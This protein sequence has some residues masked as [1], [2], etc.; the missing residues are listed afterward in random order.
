MRGV[1]ACGPA[2]AV[3]EGVM[4]VEQQR[5]AGLEQL[6]AG[7]DGGWSVWNVLQETEI[8]SKVLAT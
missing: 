5:R 7:A 6:N 1:R 3:V 4:E 2:G 8:I